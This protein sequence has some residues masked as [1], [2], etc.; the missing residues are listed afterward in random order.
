M[1]I[2]HRYTLSTTSLRGENKQNKHYDWLTEAWSRIW[3]LNI[4]VN[5]ALCNSWASARHQVITWAG[6]DLSSTGLKGQCQSKVDRY[7]QVEFL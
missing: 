1:I 6:V 7:T 5:V 4:C 3:I 2:Y